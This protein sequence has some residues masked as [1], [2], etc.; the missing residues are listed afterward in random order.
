MRSSLSFRF[1]RLC[2]V[3]LVAIFIGGLSPVAATELRPGV[4]VD[5]A[6]DVVIVAVPEGGIEAIDMQT[7]KVLWTSTSAD[8]PVVAHDGR[9][10][11]RVEASGPGRLSLKCLDVRH[12]GVLFEI[13]AALPEDVHALVD[14]R[15]GEQFKIRAD[16]DET[17]VFLT[18][19]WSYQVITGPMLE[20]HPTPRIETGTFELELDSG[21][22]LAFE[23]AREWPAAAI[24][25]DTAQRLRGF[26]GR[27][28]RSASG[29]SVLASERQRGEPAGREYIWTVL[30]KDGD[31]LGSFP[32]ARSYA[33]FH[34]TGS[35]VAYVE[36]PSIEVTKEGEV[37]HPLSLRAVN[38]EDGGDLW[39]VIFRDTTY[40]GPVPP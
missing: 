34:V 28:F 1:V 29:D 36:Y 23:A 22:L 24:E 11:A 30:S 25:L 35:V 9:L 2:I 39:V 37:F 18:W 6:S 17:S 13:E 10:V 16:A 20:E 38:A 7:G 31:E 14:D 27:Q 15:L 5:P 26:S 4:V 19:R 8:M 32:A 40:W 12:G 3:C 21:E 33:P